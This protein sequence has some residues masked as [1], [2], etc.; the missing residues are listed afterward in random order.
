MCSSVAVKV[1]RRGISGS[2]ILA[3][4]WIGIGTMIKKI[5]KGITNL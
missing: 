2:H 3:S 5:E 4:S 1:V